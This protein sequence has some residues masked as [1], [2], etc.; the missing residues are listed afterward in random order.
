MVD[1][2]LKFLS[3]PSLPRL[4]VCVGGVGGGE[5]GVTLGSRSRT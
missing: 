1:L 5:V 4:G 2:G 3:A